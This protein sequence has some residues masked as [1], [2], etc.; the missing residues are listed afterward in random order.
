MTMR[1]GSN[2]AWD[3]SS[4]DND[5]AQ[6]D[7]L[8]DWSDEPDGFVLAEMMCPSCRARVTEDTQKCPACGDWITPVDFASKGP[9]RWVYVAAVALMLLAI[10]LFTLR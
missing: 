1:R 2:D 8:D 5:M 10:L 7:D 3:D 9:K 6:E 4:D